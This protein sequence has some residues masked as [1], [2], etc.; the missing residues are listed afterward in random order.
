MIQCRLADA[1]PY[2]ALHPAFPAAFAWLRAHAAAAPEGRHDILPG[3]ACFALVQAGTTRAA[4]AGRLETHRAYLDIQM[5][6]AGGEIIEWAPAD[7]LAVADDFAPGG[8]IRFHGAP[9]RPPSRLALLPGELAILWPAD[10]HKP[11]CHLGA[12]PAAVRKV[13]VK[14]RL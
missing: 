4:D 11:L 3:D 14:V 7:G 8:D 12:A 6:L 5:S 2:A 13:V 1:D 10:G 9:S